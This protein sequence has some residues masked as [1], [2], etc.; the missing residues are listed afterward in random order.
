MKKTTLSIALILCIIHSID[1][2]LVVIENQIR[3]SEARGFDYEPSSDAVFYNDY[4]NGRV[5]KLGDV[6]GNGWFLG[7]LGV[8]TTAPKESLDVHGAIN[9]LRG[10][11]DKASFITLDH[12]PKI[13][14]SG[15]S[16]MS[17]PFTG[18]DLGHLILQ[19]RTS[20]P[21]DILFVTGDGDDI[22]MVVKG[23]GNIGVGTINPD[24]KLTVRGDIHTQEVK[25]DLNGSVAPDFVFEHN[26][27]LATLEETEK[28]IQDNKHLPGVPSS[29]E[30][31]ENGIELK[32]MNLKLLQKVEELTLYLIDQNKEIRE[33]KEKV[34]KLESNR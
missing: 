29:Q 4:N 23:N 22:R 24:A 31:E 8:G 33:L 16:G 28:F 6:G 34:L 13:W 18:S 3:F 2:Q 7:K 20:L 32:E 14:S 27:R 17:Y 15:H 30:M 12:D 26:Y 5:V 19:P 10:S 25:V 21:R 11:N 1:A 9:I